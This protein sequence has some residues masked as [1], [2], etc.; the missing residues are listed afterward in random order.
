MYKL[1]ILLIIFSSCSKNTIKKIEENYDGPLIEIKNLNT[2]FTDSAQV[3]FQLKSELY[4][5]FDEGEEIYP[6]GLYMDIYS[7]NSD[8]ITATFE[9]NHVIKFENE[10]Y[11]KA[12][13]NVVLFNIET[14]DELRTEELYWYPNDE[15]FVTQ[16]FVTIKTGDEIH[17]GEGM[18]SNQDFSSYEIIKPSGIIDIDEN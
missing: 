15:K 7:R 12:T 9:A 4:Q 10:N 8:S 5:V 2:F 11:Y 3:R 16:K 1:F 17:S 18:E 14:G 6:E 13:G